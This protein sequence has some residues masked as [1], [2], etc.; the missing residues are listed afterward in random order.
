MNLLE[1]K[2]ELDSLNLLSI[3]LSTATK[4]IVPFIL[5]GPDSQPYDSGSI[6][7]AAFLS[8]VDVQEYEKLIED[9][10]ED[11]MPVKDGVDVHKGL[12]HSVRVPVVK[13]HLTHSQYMATVRNSAGLA[14][15]KLRQTLPSI[16]DPSLF[17]AKSG[18]P[19]GREFTYYAE[20]TTAF[21]IYNAFVAM[22]ND[23]HAMASQPISFYTK[24]NTQLSTLD[25]ALLIKGQI[26]NVFIA[27]DLLKI[28]KTAVPDAIVLG[29]AEDSNF[30]RK[31]TLPLSYFAGEQADEVLQDDTITLLESEFGLEYEGKYYIPHGMPVAEKLKGKLGSVDT[32]LKLLMLNNITFKLLGHLFTKNIKPIFGKE[33][34]VIKDG[35]TYPGAYWLKLGY[36]RAG[37]KR[38]VVPALAIGNNGLGMTTSKVIEPVRVINKV[39]QP[40]TMQYSLESKNGFIQSTTCVWKP[41]PAQP[42]TEAIGTAAGVQAEMPAVNLM[43]LSM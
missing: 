17:R 37:G 25:P 27:Y 35:V 38:L 24:P 36:N 41:I 1:N 14:Q 43:D 40:S 12:L 11:E 4:E 6:H 30:V 23:I 9:D 21:H 2:Q 5:A 19:M 31:I 26:A 33:T 16:G 7:T 29:K 39:I 28:Y 3:G 20:Y 10:E 32:N 13:L 15:G 22:Y 18:K 34:P 42:K 8:D